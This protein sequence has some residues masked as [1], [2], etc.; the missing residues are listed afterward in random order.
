MSDAITVVAVCIVIIFFMFFCRGCFG[1]EQ[2]RV[3]I[4]SCSDKQASD[5][6]YNACKN[7]FEKEG[8]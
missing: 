8:N 2:A 5:E 3:C 4:T 6:C 1:D 7:L